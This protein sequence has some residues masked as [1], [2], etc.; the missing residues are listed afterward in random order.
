MEQTENNNKSINIE[1]DE[2]DLLELLGVLLRYK[3]KIFFSTLAAAIGV[4]V[5]AVVSIIMPPEKSYLPNLY[6]STTK[7]L[8]NDDSS[9][10]MLPSNLSGLASMAGI[11]VGGG[12]SY[13]NL[14][15]D[16]A[17]SNPVVDILVDEFDVID[18]YD[19]KKS[20]QYSSRIA[21]RE[22][23]S[24]K[25][26][27]DT[28]ILSIS[29]QDWEPVFSQKVVNRVVELL[30]DRFASIGVNRNLNQK[31][32]LEEKLV[33]VNTEIFGLEAEVKAFQEE[34][35]VLNLEQLAT[36]QVSSLA[37]LKS[38]LIL[39]ELEIKT[40][41]QFSRIDDPVINRMKSERN[42]LETFIRQ[43]E[44][45][46]D[47]NGY[48][49]TGPSMKELPSLALEFSHMQRELLVQAEIYKILTQE[50]EMIKLK[51]EGEG[52]IFQ[53]VELGGVA[54]KKSEPSRGMICVVVTI[55]AFF[56]AVIAVFIHNAWVNIK[57]DP[58]RM[59]KLKG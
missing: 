12:S 40:Y 24:V 48:S 30:D 47:Q 42:N 34:Y 15:V 3:W 20:P 17:S 31:S 8:I 55:A 59:S 7:L 25:L 51:V 23:L 32:L 43:I 27:E 35:G 46:E 2:I 1:D 10:S 57:N 36:I 50:Y 5:F 19:I 18:R 28:D 37:E 9:G 38:Q 13:G 11:S 54:D 26:D 44:Q 16:L 45:G 29:Y 22:R 58:K 39:K 4:L 6:S 52:P 49:Q 14:A 53:V 33:T 41:T 56:M 21:I